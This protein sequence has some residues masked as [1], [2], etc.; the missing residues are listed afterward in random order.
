M[1]LPD[2]IRF[3]QPAKKLFADVTQRLASLK[4]FEIKKRGFNPPLQPWL[5]QDLKARFAGLGHRLDA[6]TNGQLNAQ[7]VEQLVTEYQQRP[8]LAEQVLQLL[9]LDATLDQLTKLRAQA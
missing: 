7:R 5:Q 4:L 2:N 3:T 6:L 8:A 1:A 9:I